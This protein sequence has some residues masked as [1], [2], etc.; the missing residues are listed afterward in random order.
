ME[1][2]PSGFPF[3]N[4]IGHIFRHDGYSTDVGV[5]MQ[6]NC[7]THEVDVLACKDDRCYIVECKYHNQAGQTK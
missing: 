3:E 4:F 7:V 5:I 6:G 2:G 1:L